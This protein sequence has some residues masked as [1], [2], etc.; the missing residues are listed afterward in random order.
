MDTTATIDS[1]PW[2]LEIEDE[3][4]AYAEQ[5]QRD[6]LNEHYAELTRRLLEIFNDPKATYSGRGY[7]DPETT[8]RLLA[9]VLPDRV[10]YYPPNDTRRKTYGLIVM[11][12]G[13]W[14]RLPHWRGVTKEISKAFDEL[15]D[16]VTDMRISSGQPKTERRH[17]RSMEWAVAQ[18]AKSL[19]MQG[20]NMTKAV[21]QVKP[22]ITVE[23]D[24]MKSHFAEWVLEQ[25]FAERIPVSEFN[26]TWIGEDRPGGLSDDDM[27]EVMRSLGNLYENSEGFFYDFGTLNAQRALARLSA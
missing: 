11:R 13:L 2:V 15:S 12:D 20:P 14:R 17:L 7:F 8:A 1:V 16:K 23:L 5:L 18:T 27:H 22:M 10:A 4:Q 26:R 6:S 3:E 21:V 9:L 25:D 24:E 19:R